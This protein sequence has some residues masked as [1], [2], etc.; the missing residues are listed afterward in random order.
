MSSEHTHSHLPHAGPPASRA[1]RRLSLAL[2]IPVAVLT[3][4]SMVLLWPRDAPAPGTADG[5]IRVLGTVVAVQSAP[6]PAPPAGEELPAGA[7]TDCGTVTVDLT[8]GIGAGQ[9]VSTD[10][11]S[12]PGAV[13]VSAGDEVALLY[14]EESPERQY[15]IIDHQRS[16]QLWLLGAVFALAVLAF[17][18]WRGLSALAGLGVT[19]AVLLMFIV[20]A[21]LDGRSPLLV[22]IV[23]AAAIMLTVLYLTHGFSMTTT[24]AVA[25]TLVSLTITAALAAIATAAAHLSGI[26]DETSNYISITQGEVNMR[27]LLLAGIVIGS[28][29]VL[30]DVTVT[31]SA[32]VGELALANPGYGFRQLYSAATRI[33]RAHIASVIN[34]I[35]LAYAGASL[36]LMLLFAADSATP[37]GELLTSQ[38]IAQELVRSA[39]GTVGLIAAVP[40]T[41]ALAALL[42]ARRATEAGAGPLPPVP[43]TPT[44]T[45]PHTPGPLP[46]TPAPASA[47][48]ASHSARSGNDGAARRDVVDPAEPA[49][50][51]TGAVPLPAPGGTPEV[52]PWMAF[53]E[54]HPDRKP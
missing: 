39:V 26:A 54:R 24:V 11:P 46:G 31:Q 9:R 10:V 29:G 13:R 3:L 36:P 48:P 35:V 38:L 12:G 27:G 5:P 37:I 23:G 19:F 34:T 15:S 50:T 49:S 25:G 42:A 51:S 44:P 14:L 52:D 40:I 16:N 6:C 2:L 33:G 4:V 18:R 21:I 43:V 30:D 47:P 32:T 7:P 8:E 1:A 22:A 28:L 53:V 17:G 45:T 20:P 41:T